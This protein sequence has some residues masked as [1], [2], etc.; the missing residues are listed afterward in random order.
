[1]NFLSM[2]I[3]EIIFH[4]SEEF[5]REQYPNFLQFVHAYFVHKLMHL[6]LYKVRCVRHAMWI[7][8]ALTA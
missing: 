3:V 7:W 4:E 5:P 1:M 6:L 8:L 2:A